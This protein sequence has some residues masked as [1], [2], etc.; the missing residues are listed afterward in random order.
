MPP[1]DQSWVLFLITVGNSV[2]SLL[3]WLRKPGQDASAEITRFKAASAEADGVLK[4]RLDVLEERVSHMPTSK[5]LDNLK[6]EM[7]GLSNQLAGLIQQMKPLRQSL[8][9][10]E[11]YLLTERKK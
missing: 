9:R 7:H 1:I 11:N 6:T 10:V 4:G 3:L 2:A 5:E 8:D